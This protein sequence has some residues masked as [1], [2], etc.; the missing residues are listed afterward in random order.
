MITGAA[1]AIVVAAG[2]YLVVL[3]S[4]CLA[5]PARAGRF[6]SSFARSPRWHF[7]ELLVRFLVGAALV[8]AAPD[9]P[10]PAVFAFGGWI[11]V[12]TTAGLALLPWSWHR[13]IAQATVPRV[14][15]ALPPFGGA[16][17]VLGGLL[18]AAVAIGPAG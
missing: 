17:I 4:A 14:L 8:L 11:L 12:A 15:R 2:A 13:R 1:L 5:A 7:A 3:G 16:A 10:C 18:L 9:T 6:L